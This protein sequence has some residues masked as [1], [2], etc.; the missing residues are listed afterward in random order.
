[1]LTTHN[2]YLW[3]FNPT[4]LELDCWVDNVFVP[5]SGI[6][7]HAIG[8]LL[9]QS[10]SLV[11]SAQDNIATYSIYINLCLAVLIFYNS[12]YLWYEEH[13]CSIYRL[14]IKFRAHLLF[15]ELLYIYWSHEFYSSLNFL[16][17][18]HTLAIN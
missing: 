10:L 5:L 16:T 18:I 9:H 7:T 13:I 11:S 15:M 14:K 2:I 3:K 8:T 6:W 12:T 4:V 1:L 17:Y